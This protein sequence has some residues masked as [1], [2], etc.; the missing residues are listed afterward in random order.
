MSVESEIANAESRVAGWA[1]V[2][3]LLVTELRS[4]VAD[5][6]SG[7]YLPGIKQA[8]G[9]VTSGLDI[10]RIIFPEYSSP[11]TDDMPMPV[12]EPPLSTLP[13]KPDLADIASVN[14]PAARVEPT[15]NIEGLFEQALPSTNLPDFTESNPDLRITEL[16]EE[17]DAIAAPILS[18]ITFP[19]LTPLTIRDTPIIDTP[20]FIESSAP[21]LVDPSDYAAKYD[22]TY[23]QMLPE[24]Q[25]WVDERTKVYLDTYAP[26][27]ETTRSKWQSALQ[28]ALDGGGVLPDQFENAMYIR[29]QGR[30]EKEF[31]VAEQG[32]RQSAETSGMLYPPGAVLSG[33]LLTRMKSAESLANQA[34][35]IYIERS[36]QEAQFY[37]FVLGQAQNYVDNVRNS[38]ISY[39]GV[40]ANNMQLSMTYADSVTQRIE[41]LFDHLMARAQ[42]SLSIMA[43]LR[44]QYDTKL[45]SALARVEGF[46]VEL[47]AE[48]TKKD[49]ELSVITALEAQIRAESLQVS[50]YTALIDAVARKSSLEELKL[51]D[52][53]IRADIFKYNTDAR[54]AAFEVYKA[55]LSGDKSK[56][57][58]ELAKLQLYESQLKSDQINLEAQTEAIKAAVAQN[59]GIIKSYTVEADAYKLESAIALQKFNA[60]AEVKKLHQAIYG[61]ELENAIKEFTAKFETKKILVDQIFK[62]YEMSV[63]TAIQEAKLDITNLQIAEKA[64]EAAVDAY[65][66]MATAALGSLNT[67]VSSALTA[68]A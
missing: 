12:Y 17:M 10:S 28:K 54:L 45:K 19:T 15:L 11:A 34:T 24:M 46:K 51:K 65:K 30:A 58:G 8:D 25:S 4:F 38:V 21:T 16:V 67:V 60:Y 32:L 43:E 47:E 14:I 35:D 40:I 31:N 3:D 9:T 55:A 13:T 41:K 18:T 39:A 33:E 68:A 23:R 36:R 1:A 5:R 2:T 20:E 61:Q 6:H 50:R 48:K 53:S 62:Q 52:Y 37:Q 29:A 49:V 7:L 66:S 64:S 26:D 57:D 27:Y 59:D 63:E 42:M 56:L 44:A 22:E